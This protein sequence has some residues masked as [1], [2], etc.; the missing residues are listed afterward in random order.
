MVYTFL[1]VSLFLD[2]SKVAPCTQLEIDIQAGTCKPQQI[3]GYCSLI[4]MPDL[5]AK[6]LQLEA[7]QGSTTL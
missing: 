2:P 4:Y 7:V 6:I 1:P 3:T 5:H